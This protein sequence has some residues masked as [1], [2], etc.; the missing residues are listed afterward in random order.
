M[1][2]KAALPIRLPEGRE[3][4]RSPQDE[5]RSGPAPRLPAAQV[6]PGLRGAPACALRASAKEGG[7]PHGVT[8]HGAPPPHAVPAARRP[9]CTA[10]PPHG[11]P[12]PLAPPPLHGDPAMAPP[13]MAPLRRT[14]PLCT[15][16]PLHT[17]HHHGTAPPGRCAWCRDLG[18]HRARTLV[19]RAW[20]LLAEVGRPRRA[21][22]R[23]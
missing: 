3:R 4:A 8:P 18:H 13:R 7:P 11:A 23:E 22:G 17:P 15:A 2:S 16:P 10:P 12:P 5:G 20:A 9:P 21:H 1:G 14:A 6:R 19:R